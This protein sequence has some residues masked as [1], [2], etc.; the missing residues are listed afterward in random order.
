[1]RRIIYTAD[2]EE[3]DCGRCD[4]VYDSDNLCINYCGPEHGWARYVR[5]DLVMTDRERRANGSTMES[6]CTT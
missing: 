1:M 4:H 3:P 6:V 5:T 2:D